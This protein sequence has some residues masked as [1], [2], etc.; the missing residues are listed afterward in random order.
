MVNRFSWMFCAFALVSCSTGQASDETCEQLKKTG[1][2]WNAQAPQM[3][4]DQTE[5]IQVLVNCEAMTVTYQKRVL[6]TGNALVPGTQERKQQ[7]H[8]QLH[9]NQAGLASVYGW[10][11]VDVLGDVDYEYLFTLKTQ[12]SDCS[13]EVGVP[14]SDTQ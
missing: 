5:L 4:D 6:L 10:T 8:T 7:Q 2:E 12:P 9:C 13:N 1:A 11:A 14:Q 3:I